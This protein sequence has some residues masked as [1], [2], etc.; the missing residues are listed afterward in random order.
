M[1]VF[2]DQYNKEVFQARI[3]PTRCCVAAFQIR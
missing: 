3:P 2:N 1:I